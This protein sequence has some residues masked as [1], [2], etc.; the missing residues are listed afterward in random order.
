MLVAS[1]SRN[2]SLQYSINI[3]VYLMRRSIANQ[4]F[5][6]VRGLTR[7]ER[8]QDAHIS[9]ANRSK[10]DLRNKG[11]RCVVI[12]K[13]YIKETRFPIFLKHRAHQQNRNGRKVNWVRYVL[14]VKV[15]SCT[16]N[17]NILALEVSKPIKR[18]TPKRPNDP[19][20]IPV[21]VLK[22]PILTV[23]LN[24]DLKANIFP[25]TL[26]SVFSMTSFQE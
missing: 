5:P 15:C 11:I 26:E 13:A 7:T 20:K 21:I 3:D 25:K 4:H 22:P 9:R 24:N 18:F 8:N 19:D 10:F 1:K 2:L 14:A 17:E 6:K 23:S 16:T 12:W